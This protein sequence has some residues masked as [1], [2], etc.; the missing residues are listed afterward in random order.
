MNRIEFQST[1]WLSEVYGNKKV[2]KPA[3]VTI[4]EVSTKGL[5]FISSLRLPINENV[6]WSFQFKL[7]EAILV[8]EGII[9]NIVTGFDGENF[10]Y[11][12]LWR[13]YKKS[14][15]DYLRALINYNVFHRYN[16]QRK[17]IDLLC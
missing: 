3:K 12:A 4:T 1:I 11:S 5:K 14:Q 6:I 8:G 15:E 7:G 13:G 17:L 9:S 10:E 2:S 16:S